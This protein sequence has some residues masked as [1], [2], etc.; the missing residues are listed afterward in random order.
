MAYATTTELADYL[1]VNEADLPSDAD[2]L[3]DRASD[4]IDYYTLDRIDETVT[5]EANAA[6][7]A[8]MAQYEWW[9]EFDEFMTSTFLSSI[10]IGPFSADISGGSNE[11]QIPELAPRAR[12]YLFLSGLLYGG[13]DI[14]IT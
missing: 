6:K 4:T 5:E 3:L 13:V 1:G 8:T 10:D 7:K 11:N 2:R 9:S 12:R 14:E